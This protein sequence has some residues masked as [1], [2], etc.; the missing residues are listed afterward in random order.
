LLA[1][2]KKF[3]KYLNQSVEFKFICLPCK[4]FL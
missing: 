4:F 1:S 2:E 3:S